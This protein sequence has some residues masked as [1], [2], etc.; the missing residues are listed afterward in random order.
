MFATD[1]TIDSLQALF[2]EVK[3][4]VDL[5]KDYVKL[6]ITHKLTVLLSTLIL[7]LILV[8]LGMIALFYLSFTLAYILEPHVGG[9]VNSYAIITAGMGRPPLTRFT[10]AGIA[11]Y[12]DRE[13]PLAG[14][15]LKRFV[16]GGVPLMSLDDACRH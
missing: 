11:V 15:V 4:Y 2:T 7:I 13:L 8:V 3:H 14:D 5:Q 16:A 6:D 10:A 12:A 1:K 9:L